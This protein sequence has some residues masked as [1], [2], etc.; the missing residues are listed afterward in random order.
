MAKKIK[1][2]KFTDGYKDRAKKA[3]INDTYI[4]KKWKSIFLTST[5]SVLPAS[6]QQ[7]MKVGKMVNDGT[8]KAQPKSTTK[9]AGK[10]QKGSATKK[11]AGI[12]KKS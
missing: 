5:Q 11:S 2:L 9:I 6:T 7:L 3:G 4:P 8:S 1:Y 10:K 12:N